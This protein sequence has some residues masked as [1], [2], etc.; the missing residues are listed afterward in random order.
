M[1]QVS[2]ALASLRTSVIAGVR[3]N[4]AGATILIG[5]QGLQLV[6]L[7]RMLP[8]S[9]FGL[10]A[11]C[12]VV[13]AFAES[14]SAAGTG[15][16][17]I[18]RQSTS[19]ALLATSTALNLIVGLGIALVVFLG[20]PLLADVFNE[21]RLILLVRTLACA[22]FISAIGVVPHQILRRELEFKTLVTSQVVAMALATAVSITMAAAG[23]GVMSLVMGFITRTS[24]AT[25]LVTWATWRKM[26]FGRQFRMSREELGRL[27]RFGAPQ[28]SERLLGIAS[29]R[30]DVALV[31]VIMGA[32]ILG[33]YAF[34]LSLVTIPQ[35]RINPIATSVALPAFSKLQDKDT[36]LGTAFCRVLRVVTA[37]NA[38]LLLGLVVT[39]PVAI[40][41]A[42]G[43]KWT[44]AIPVVQLLSLVGLGRAVGN[45]V[46]S[47]L[48]ATGAVWRAFAWSVGCVSV[49]IVAV[50]TS[51]LLIGTPS[52]VAFCT[53]LI[54]LLLVPATYLFLVRPTSN[55]SWYEYI[56]AIGRPVIAAA[57]GAA[58]AWLPSFVFERGT[59]LAVIQVAVFIAAYPVALQAIDPA[60]PREL[61]QLLR[62][63]TPRTE[64]M[65]TN[66]GA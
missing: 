55:A 32:E 60:S 2:P 50:L 52:G 61:M 21:P 46:G 31:G 47:L 13:M 54:Q 56:D 12:T 23:A 49:T 44:P 18:Y 51:C 29:D 58:L 39:A 34:A 25:A 65:S 9:D 22:T 14:L 40:P 17:I 16:Y 10:M 64:E 66:T 26:D 57:V 42:F 30:A 38:P 6:V 53:G 7:S 43:D 28:L 59:V 48:V 20:A 11:M 62:R 63:N 24:A 4:T 36:I 45:P 3:W 8:P 5:L 1:N 19:T 41:L 37:I 27:V 35:M 15:N 33:Y